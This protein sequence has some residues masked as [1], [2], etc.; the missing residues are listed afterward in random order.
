MEILSMY[1]VLWAT[2][3]SNPLWVD[4]E[5]DF[6]N[7][8]NT[9]IISEFKNFKYELHQHEIICITIQLLI[10]AITPLN[11]MQKY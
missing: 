8:L 9:T 7:A 10:S 2:C 1:G 4:D 6:P 5:N 11:Q 3:G